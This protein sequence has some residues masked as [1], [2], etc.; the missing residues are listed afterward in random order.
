MKSVYLSTGRY[1]DVDD[2]AKYEG[3]LRRIGEALQN[4][5]SVSYD[6]TELERLTRQKELVEQFS[7][8]GPLLRLFLP[9]ILFIGALV[10]VYL[11]IRYV[12]S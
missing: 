8:W 7:P 10:I 3:E 6:T 5:E 2:Q 4:G 9:A 11:L 12:R 1:E